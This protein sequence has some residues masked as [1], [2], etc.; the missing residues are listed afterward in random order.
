MGGETI[1]MKYKKKEAGRKS[2]E[3]GRG[4]APHQE[5][6]GLGK[7]KE[8]KLKEYMYLPYNEKE[9]KENAQT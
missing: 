2:R 6:T 3:G 8:G 1:T 5:R 4:R 7:T 9:R